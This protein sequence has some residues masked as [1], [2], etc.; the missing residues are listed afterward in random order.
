MTQ[1]LAFQ[2]QNYNWPLSTALATFPVLRNV[3]MTF[4]FLL[5]KSIEDVQKI[6]I[7]S[8]G[9]YLDYS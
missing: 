9:A 5:S 6:Y 3:Y 4:T 7:F 2:C 8:A 1:Q